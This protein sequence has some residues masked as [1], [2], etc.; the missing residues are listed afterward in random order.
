MF[1]K[2]E[3]DQ[4]SKAKSPF[5]Y[6]YQ[7]IQPAK[8]CIKLNSSVGLNASINGQYVATQTHQNMVPMPKQYQAHNVPFNNISTLT[9]PK[10]SYQQHSIHPNVYNGMGGN[11]NPGVH[12]TI[13]TPF[14][15][16]NS[17]PQH[18]YRGQDNIIGMKANE[19]RKS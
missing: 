10:I 4:G 8:A 3:F 16:K 14:T 6:Q 15:I 13:H 1:N 11:I 2:G 17:L 9:S 7:A 19:L 5:N 18:L 12:N